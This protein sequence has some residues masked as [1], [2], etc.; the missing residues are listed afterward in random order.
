[1]Y[2]ALKK[3]RYTHECQF[4]IQFVFVSMK[5][6][7]CYLFFTNVYHGIYKCKDFYWIQSCRNSTNNVAATHFKFA[8]LS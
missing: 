8:R 2:R 1:M 7:T 6:V 4:W 3:N 5:D